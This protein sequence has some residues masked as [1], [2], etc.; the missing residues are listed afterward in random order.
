MEAIKEAV[1]DNEERIKEEEE[2]ELLRAPQV[3]IDSNSTMN[4]ERKGTRIS[5]YGKHY[6]QAS[7]NQNHIIEEALND[8]TSL[9][10]RQ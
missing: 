2:R 4:S 10:I 9:S 5:P 1:K 6:A 8:Y 3:I 7:N